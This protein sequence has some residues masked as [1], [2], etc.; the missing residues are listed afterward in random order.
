MKIPFCDVGR[1]NRALETQ[2]TEAAQRVIRSGRVLYGPE[3]EAFEQEIAAWHGVKHAVGVASGTDAIEVALRATGCSGRFVATSAMTAVPTVNA[4]EAADADVILVDPE[5]ETRTALTTHRREVRVHLYGLALPAVGVTVEDV[6]HAMGATV[7]GSMAGTM[8]QCGALSFYPTKIFG[9][10]GDGGAVITNDDEIAKRARRIRH[11]GVE[12][13]GDIALRGQNSRLSEIQAAFLR[14]KLGCVNEWIRRRREI[15]ARYSA[16]LGARVKTPFE[17]P[18][19][20]SVY[21]VYVMEHPERDRIAKG[22]AERGIGTMVH[23]PR[24]IHEYDRWSLLGRDGAFPV[25]ERLAREVLSLPC[26][27]FLE[28]AEQDAVIAA[29]KELT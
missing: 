6:A 10:L 17:P 4:I 23:Y 25:A 21:H 22:L 26:Y 9:A 7:D 19:C 24:A 16:E 11:Y 13:D 8:G 29:V 1:E 15:A 12:E 20:Q 27:P 18:G 2:L 28:E 3:L 5:P 14:V